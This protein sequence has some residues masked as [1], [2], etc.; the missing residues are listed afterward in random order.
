MRHIVLTRASFENDDMFKK[1]YEVMKNVYIPSIL[2]QTCKNFELYIMVNEQ[3]KSFLEDEFIK[4]GIKITTIVGNGHTYNRYA[5]KNLIEIQTRHD[6]DDWMAPTYIES[7][8]SKCEEHSKT[9]DTFLVQGQPTKLDY[10]TGNEYKMGIYPETRTSMF[11]TLYQKSGNLSIMDQSH[12]KFPTLVPT[13]FSLEGNPVKW[14]IHGNNTQGK[15]KETDIR[16]S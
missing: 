9:F 4:H 10:H 16:I 13:V 11:L 5:R 12:T 7:I 1:Y 2:S 14:V 8:R 3:H 15:I 6:C